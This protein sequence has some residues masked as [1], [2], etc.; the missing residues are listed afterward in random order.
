MKYIDFET[1]YP[2]I[3]QVI[4][5]KDTKGLK[6][7]LWNFFRAESY[8]YIP[9]AIRKWQG[10]D[11]K[12]SVLTEILSKERKMRIVTKD[13]VE[14]GL[15]DLE[16]VKENL[17]WGSD[18]PRPVILRYPLV[19]RPCPNCGTKTTLMSPEGIWRCWKCG[20]QWIDEFYTEKAIPFTDKT[21]EQI[22]EEVKRFLGKRE[23]RTVI[24]PGE[25]LEET[26]DDL[27]F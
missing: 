27:P 12:F 8:E 7:R 16:A 18:T 17:D 20:E 19:Y 21:P 13:M 26:Y 22:K 9:D 11:N 4:K 1:I 14:Q 24:D 5:R 3:L 10:M 6:M 15:I 23:E 2:A 25:Q